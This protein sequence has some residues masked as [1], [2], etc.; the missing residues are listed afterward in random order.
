MKEVKQFARKYSF[1]F[2]YQL[3]LENKKNVSD[4]NFDF[5][6]LQT[7]MKNFEESFR[8]NTDGPFDESQISMAKEF[9]KQS[10]DNQESIKESLQA[11]IKNWK[12]NEI[13]SIDLALLFVGSYELLY[14]DTPKAVVI[15][16]F[17]SLAKEYGTEKSASFINGILDGIA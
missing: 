8:E 9:I 17:V 2:F 7:Q 10:L 3:F 4:T 12:L 14:R 5:S 15:N 11:K 1:R 13:N 6:Q 16:E